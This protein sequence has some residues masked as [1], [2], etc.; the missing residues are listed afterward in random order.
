MRFH[1]ATN[2]GGNCRKS[3]L[4]LTSCSRKIDSLPKQSISPG[5]MLVSAMIIPMCFHRSKIGGAFL[6]SRFFQPLSETLVRIAEIGIFSLRKVGFGKYERSHE[7]FT[8]GM[9]YNDHMKD[10]R[11]GS[12]PP[13]TPLVRW[14]SVGSVVKS[15]RAASAHPLDKRNTG[16]LILRISNTWLL[17]YFVV[18]TRHGR[19]SRGSGTHLFLKKTHANITF[20]MRCRYRR[21]PEGF[22][23]SPPRRRETPLP[24]MCGR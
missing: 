18:T 6:Q 5:K 1:T 2:S 20:L 17:S 19:A 24:P 10:F 7:S 11:Y 15:C 13:T 4:Y 3:R 22:A 14:V 8:S 9:T 23:T 16:G 21:L 12:C